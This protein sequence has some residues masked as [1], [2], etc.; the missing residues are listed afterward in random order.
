MAVPVL[1]REP[2]AHAPARPS[3]DDLAF[4]HLRREFAR[5]SPGQ[6]VAEALS[7][8]R[9]QTLGESIVYLYVVDEYDHLFGVVPL[10]RLL[11]AP[12][13]QRID[14][15]M[16]TEIVSLPADATV[17]QASQLFLTHRLLALPVVGALGR[18]YGVVDVA[19]L[20]LDV[21]AHGERRAADEV[22]Q[23]VGLH[24]SSAATART[25]FRAR[26]PSLLWNVA[27]G[28][29][30]AAIAASYES[31]I[32]TVV[33]LALFLPVILSLSESVS[34]QSVTLTLQ[35]L[36]G[37]RIDWRLLRGSIGREV[38]TAT[39]LGAGCGALIGGIAW[40]WQGR[41][42]FA[43]SVTATVTTAMVAAAAVGVVLPG[44][45]RALRR[46]PQVASGPLV[47]A[48]A[49][50]VTLLL[51]FGIATAMLG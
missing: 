39:L 29:V 17:A 50:F 38:A 7:S 47:L 2:D 13:E 9:A 15:L 35:S 5:V 18:M 12:P 26:F 20:A 33:V 42:W 37:R 11:T 4:A 44:A 46:D 48:I 14:A 10:R 49:D 22:F 1:E 27:G 31:L 41:A 30:A 51:Y 32:E 28:L 24:L 40:M 43:V 36:R 21:S 23:L 19:M 34:M 8:L 25:G 16:Q 3:P 6:T 45:L